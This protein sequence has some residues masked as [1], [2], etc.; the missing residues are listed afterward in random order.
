MKAQFK[1][2]FLA[3]LYARGPVFAVIFVM[4]TVFIV[5]GSMGLLPLP[6][7]ITAVSLGGVAVAVMMAFNIVGDISVIRRIYHAPGAYLYALTPIPRWKTLLSS[8]IAMAVMDLISMFIV[9]FQI[10]WLS[11]NLSG[12]WH[13]F[14]EAVRSEPS[15][16]VYMLWAS[17]YLT[18]GYLLM[19]TLILFC[20]T[21]KRSI[22]F[23]KPASGLL[24]FLLACACL[25][26]MSLVQM[27]LAPFGTVARYGLIFIIS[28][29]SEVLP[30]YILLIF[31]EAAVL[32]VLASKLLERRVNI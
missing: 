8:I 29:G 22:F 3:G 27:I 28:F 32:F 7:H 6:A 19:V 23:K 20:I 30:F 9:I 11:L 5:L 1:Y 16:Y 31:L 25:Y 24:C 2:A 17:L 26:V 12:V 18:A 4:N 21:A 10:V 14:I 13:V 15:Y